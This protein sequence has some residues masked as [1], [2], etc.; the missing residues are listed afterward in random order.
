VADDHPIY[1]RGLINF[2]KANFEECIVDEA[3][4]SQALLNAMD[5]CN[6]DLIFID[7][8]MPEV[9]GIEATRMIIQK[10]PSTKII[11]VSFYEDDLHAISMF[12]NGAMGFLSKNAPEKDIILA[13]ETVLSG[14]LFIPSRNVGEILNHRSNEYV[15]ISDREKEVLLLICEGLSN[16]EIATRLHLSLKTVENH[17]T[18]LHDK[19]GTHNT[20][21]LVMYA[22][23]KGWV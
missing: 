8:R 12:E 1:R 5:E 14:T 7:I 11:G 22:S 6:Y 16:K 2:L 10:N 21:A 18:H 19:I 3:E 17:R 23:R 13:V 15:G 9:N 20:A 4:N